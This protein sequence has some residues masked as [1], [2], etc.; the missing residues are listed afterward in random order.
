MYRFPH[1]LFTK[2]N[3]MQTRQDHLR[4]LTE[5]YGELLRAQNDHDIIA[6]T[7]DV[8]HCAE[9]ILREFPDEQVQAALI[10]HDVKNSQR[11]YYGDEPN[12]NPLTKPA[13]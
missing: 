13:E 2:N 3:P 9:E 1:I 6:E 12:N 4:K 11:G 10:E 7:L 5:E 8:I